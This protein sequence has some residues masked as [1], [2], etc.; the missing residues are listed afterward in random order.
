M[1]PRRHDDVVLWHRGAVCH[2][3]GVDRPW[4]QSGAIDHR[5]GIAGRGSLAFR[6]KTA[7]GEPAERI[8]GKSPSKVF[9]EQSRETP[10][11]ASA[12]ALG[13]WLRTRGT[14][15]EGPARPAI[16]LSTIGGAGP[17]PHSSSAPKSA[18]IRFRD[19]PLTRGRPF[20]RDE[21]NPRV[22]TEGLSRFFDRMTEIAAPSAGRYARMLAK[23][24]P[25]VP[26]PRSH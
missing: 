23:S 24:R 2:I 9:R 12:G 1:V 16:P 6:C 26:A 5:H 22:G 15:P 8:T 25:G 18:A 20:R 14:G 11:T 19:P 3:G 21:S 17:I 4:P 10:L 13:G 7:T